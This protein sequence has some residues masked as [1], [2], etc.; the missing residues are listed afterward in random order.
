VNKRFSQ[1]TSI[2]L[3]AVLLLTLIVVMPSCHVA[4]AEE[5]STNS[6]DNWVPYGVNF[7]EDDGSLVATTDEFTAVLPGDIN[8][9]D[10][11]QFNCGGHWFTYKL[12]GGKIQWAYT[13]KDNESTKSIGAVLSSSPV[14]EGNNAT[15]QDA[16]WGTDIQYTA[17]SYGLRE[18]FILDALPAGA[19]PAKWTDIYLEYTGELRW[20]DGLSVWADGVE[21]PDKTFSTSGRVDFKDSSGETVFYIPEPTAWDSDGD[22]SYLVYDVK[23]SAD[24]IQ[25]GLRVPYEFLESAT[26]PVYIDPDNWVSPT[27]YND[28]SSDWV[29]E[30]NAYDDATGTYAES[31]DQGSY[32]ELTISAI[33][34]D[35]VRIY[36]VRWH[37][38]SSSEY[39]PDIDID[40]YYDSA[41]HNIFSGTV[42]KNT[43][44]TKSIGSTEAVTKARVKCN[45]GLA[46]LDQIRLKEFDFNSVVPDMDTRVRLQ[47][48][49]ARHGHPSL[50]GRGRQ[51]IHCQRGNPDCCRKFRHHKGLSLF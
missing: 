11:V 13:E 24:K 2:I 32:L 18:V 45:D 7:V 29:N 21:H 38:F 8:S 43:W 23:V 36:A 48:R 35:K 33:A 5:S 16:F 25:Y 34:C 49:R 3:V 41:W 39:D 31:N 40:V 9:G 6:T 46:A 12:S 1:Q 51:F 28:P 17:H 20:D 42:T 47:L 19:D 30:A 22:T 37:D 50:L 14:Y 10:G 15:Y 44:I 26:Y 27:G 4:V